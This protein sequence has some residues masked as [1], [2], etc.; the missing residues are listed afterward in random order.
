MTWS[1]SE[2]LS[3][4]LRVSFVLPVRPV[5]S[6]SEVVS[7]VLW[8]SFLGIAVY[9]PCGARSVHALSH[10]EQVLVLWV[11]F[12]SGAEVALGAPAVAG[13]NATC[14]AGVGSAPHVQEGPHQSD[15]N[16]GVGICRI[17]PEVALVALL[18]RTGACLTFG[19]GGFAG[20][21]VVVSSIGL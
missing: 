14:L 16:V 18:G 5:S 15:V 7:L 4:V 13:A 2:H 11:S 10:S 6:H 12:L 9:V 20:F 3:L 19:R 1:R 21:V 17:R 8:V